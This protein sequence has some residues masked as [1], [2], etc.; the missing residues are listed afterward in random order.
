MSKDTYNREQKSRLEIQERSR[1]T[2]R[3]KV[4]LKERS[5]LIQ[6]TS[7]QGSRELLVDGLRFQLRDDGSKLMRVSGKQATSGEPCAI[8]FMLN[9]VDAASAVKE[10]PKRVAIADV[11]FFRTKNGN[12]VRANAIRDLNRLQR[13][14]HRP[15]CE[16]FTKHGTNL[17]LLSTSGCAIIIDERS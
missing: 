2:K 3:Q 8:H 13:Q 7:N 12:L 9:S 1:V 15:Q 11:N 4:D 14:Q 5:R 17:P 10:T 6:H 16:D